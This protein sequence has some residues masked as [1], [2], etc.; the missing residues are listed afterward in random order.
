[1][2]FLVTNYIFARVFRLRHP[3][4]DLF[5]GGPDFYPF[6]TDIGSANVFEDEESVNT[7]GKILIEVTDSKNKVWDIQ[8]SGKN[9]I[10]YP[11]HGNKNQLF[12]VIHIA[13]DVIAIESALGGCFQYIED[14]K[15]FELTNCA[16]DTNY[17]NQTFL[18]TNENGVW[19]GY[20]SY[21]EG[22]GLPSELSVKW[23][24]CPTCISGGFGSLKQGDSLDL[25]STI[26]TVKKEE[27][28][29]AFMLGETMGYDTVM[30]QIAISETDLDEESRIINEYEEGQNLVSDE[31][32]TN[33]T[34]NSG[35]DAVSGT[36]FNKRKTPTGLVGH[37]ALHSVEEG[38]EGPYTSSVIKK[39]RINET[40]NIM[41]MGGSHP[42]YGAI[43]TGIYR[44]FKSPFAFTVLGQ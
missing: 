11:K 18:I 3:E 39:N 30:T 14:N 20:G 28:D 33:E 12:N 17:L 13:R 34:V 38:D 23:G 15:R 40:K 42:S 5:V 22:W 8:A 37:G 7:A 44:G 4:K 24:V 10:Y 16:I 25:T 43:M 26:D 1:M 29:N 2:V 41:E 36:D 19:K 35:S 32:N 6:F 27:L 21:G 9:L 31:T